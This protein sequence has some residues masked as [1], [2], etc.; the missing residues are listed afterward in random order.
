MVSKKGVIENDHF[1]VFFNAF[2]PFMRDVCAFSTHIAAVVLYFCCFL[3]SLF[4]PQQLRSA[5]NARFPVKI[6]EMLS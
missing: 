6:L 1:S 5:G 4:Q 2:T 3:L